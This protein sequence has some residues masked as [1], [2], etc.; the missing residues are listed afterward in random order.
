MSRLLTKDVKKILDETIKAH[1]LDSRCMEIFGKDEAA[2]AIC[3]LSDRAY[4]ERVERI[5][6][7]LERYLA[8]DLSLPLEELKLWREFWKQEGISD[9]SSM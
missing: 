9:L 4:Q 3:E 7:E 2:K 8:E 5:K 1:S 6:K